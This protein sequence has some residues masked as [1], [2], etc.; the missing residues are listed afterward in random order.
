MTERMNRSYDPK[1][2]RRPCAAQG[3]PG[4][5]KDNAHGQTAQ[6]A[7]T[8]RLKQRCEEGPYRL[9][10]QAAEAHHPE[11]ASGFPRPAEKR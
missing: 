11:H 8:P 5:T 3:Y 9:P 1:D 10:R 4:D 6:R 7:G 2:E